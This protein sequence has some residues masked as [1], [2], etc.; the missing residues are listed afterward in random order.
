MKGRLGNKVRIIH[1][2]ESIEEIQDAVKGHTFDSFQNERIL[3]MAVV[4]WFEII[5][6]AA[7]HLTNELKE[8]HPD[9][10]WRDIIGLRNVLVHEYFII[11]YEAIW[12]AMSFLAELKKTLQAINLDLNDNFLTN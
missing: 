8:K 9:I 1:I 4:K 6:E 10:K 5:G 11:D 12:Q 3:Q 2:L 7:N